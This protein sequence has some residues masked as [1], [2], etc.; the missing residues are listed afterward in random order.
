MKLFRSLDR[1]QAIRKR[2]EAI[3]KPCK[4][5]VLG[6]GSGSVRKL[7]GSQSRSKSENALVRAWRFRPNLIYT[8]K[9]APNLAPKLCPVGPETGDPGGCSGSEKTVENVTFEPPGA[10]SKPG[11]P[12]SFFWPLDATDSGGSSGVLLDGFGV[13]F[14]RPLG[15]PSGRLWL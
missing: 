4:L 12:A 5:G 15:P 2:P 3:R 8:Y 7:S 10:L 9:R 14:W 1:P 11:V 13:S 6:R